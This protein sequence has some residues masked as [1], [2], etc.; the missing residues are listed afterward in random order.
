MGIR[1]AVA[2]GELFWMKVAVALQQA[3]GL[4]EKAIHA[5]VAR[6]VVRPG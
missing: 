5:M 1:G 6:E 2:Q 4:F 3:L